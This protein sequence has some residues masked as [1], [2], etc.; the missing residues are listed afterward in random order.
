M[1]EAAAVVESSQPQA[2]NISY[3][4]KPYLL[5]LAII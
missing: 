1:I 2:S 3:K 4:F 5:N